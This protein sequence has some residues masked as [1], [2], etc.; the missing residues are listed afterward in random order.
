VV[1][2]VFA[3]AVAGVGSATGA[4]D[5]TGG[6]VEL[7]NASTAGDAGAAMLILFMTGD[8]CSLGLVSRLSGDGLIGA[9]DATGRGGGG[10]GSMDGDLELKAGVAA[11][12][13]RYEARL[14]SSSAGGDVSDVDM[15]RPERLVDVVLLDGVAYGLP[16]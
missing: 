3:A 7:A 1:C 13:G 16:P 9:D 4:G 15:A 14:A 8:V 11:P 6:A 10:E 2:E 5:G 12:S